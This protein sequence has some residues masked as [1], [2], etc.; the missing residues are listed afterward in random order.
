MA[1]RFEEFV[2]EFVRGQFPDGKIPRW[3]AESLSSAGI[4]VRMDGATFTDEESHPHLERKRQAQ[5]RRKQDRSSPE[6]RKHPPKKQARAD[7]VRDGVSARLRETENAAA[8]KSDSA[9]ADTGAPSE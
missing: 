1:G 6:Q 5:A 9:R 7:A 3:V 2:R 4:D 8:Q